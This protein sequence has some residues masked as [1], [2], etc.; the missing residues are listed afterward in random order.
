[1][2]TDADK[3]EKLKKQYENTANGLRKIAKN[4]K[5]MRFLNERCGNIDPES[6]DKRF[7]MFEMIEV[8]L[9]ELRKDNSNN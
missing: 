9:K 1:M 2:N 8:T 3:I 5:A 7:E 4:P 6:M